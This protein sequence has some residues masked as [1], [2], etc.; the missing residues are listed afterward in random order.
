M[1]IQPFYIERLTPGW[2]GRQYGNDHWVD[3]TP[4]PWLCKTPCAVL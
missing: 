4:V 3:R 1:A 2:P